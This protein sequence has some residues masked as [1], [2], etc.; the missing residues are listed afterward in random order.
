M[1]KAVI[2]NKFARKFDLSKEARPATDPLPS[3]SPTPVCGIRGGS[4]RRWTTSPKRTKTPSTTLPSPSKRNGKGT[5]GAR[6]KG[7]EPPNPHKYAPRRTRSLLSVRFQQCLRID[8]KHIIC[9]LRYGVMLLGLRR[10]QE[11]II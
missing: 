10:L 11:D 6:K 1:R 9:S 8:P 7:T 2:T 3:L 4:R 5:P